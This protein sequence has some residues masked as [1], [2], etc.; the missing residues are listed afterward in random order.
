M[1]SGDE[2]WPQESC[3]DLSTIPIH[4]AMWLPRLAGFIALRVISA[5]VILRAVVV[6]APIAKPV[7][8]GQPH[9]PLSATA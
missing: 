4:N 8:V 9:V 2:A 3:Q 7:T 1:L 5:L 6:P